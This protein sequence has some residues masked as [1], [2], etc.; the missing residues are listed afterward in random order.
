MLILLI[1]PLKGE[2]NNKTIEN[3]KSVIRLKVLSPGFVFERRLKNN[4]TIVFDL[5]TI[6]SPTK[7]IYFLN[8]FI[9]IESR[10]YIN[11]NKRRISGKRTDYYSGQYVGL[12]VGTGKYLNNDE[13]WW[14]IG[15]IWG[16]QR[17]LYNKWYW[18]IGLGPGLGSDNTE[19][20]FYIVGGVGIGFIIK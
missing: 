8:P 5:G 9:K 1:F 10:K 17:T 12:Q 15:P 18:N 11:S 2:L 13:K 14:S 7:S 19:P 3:P 16:F 20:S 6:F 4:S